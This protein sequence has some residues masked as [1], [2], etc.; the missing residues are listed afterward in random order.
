MIEDISGQLN[1]YLFEIPEAPTDGSFNVIQSPH[2]TIKLH[3]TNPTQKRAA[4]DFYQNILTLYPNPNNYNG[5][6]DLQDRMNFLPFH[7]TLKIQ[8]R[9][10]DICGNV[11]P[12]INVLNPDDTT[13]IKGPVGPIF[14]NV[15]NADFQILVPPTTRSFAEQDISTTN[16]LIQIS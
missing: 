15:S 4:L 1:R 2:P 11:N 9:S 5:L 3:W 16:I 13:S 10:K 12:W 8:R 6:S 7:N 14:K